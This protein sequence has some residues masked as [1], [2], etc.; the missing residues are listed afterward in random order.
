[1]TDAP[2]TARPGGRTV[3]VAG[4]VVGAAAIL[5]ASAAWFAYTS[6]PSWSGALSTMLRE[7][8][9]EEIYRTQC[10]SCHAGPTGG[11]IDDYPPRHN[12]NG[13]TWHHPDCSLRLAIREGSQVMSAMAPPDAPKMP[14]FKDRLSADDIDAVLAYIKTMWTPGQREVQASFTREMC[15]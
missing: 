2:R 7:R 14:A 1:M 9:G 8:R 6:A 13:H 11:R 12:A 10:F 5:F 4:F 15:F 3:V